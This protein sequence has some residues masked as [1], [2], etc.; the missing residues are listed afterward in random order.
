[1]SAHY[2]TLYF[3]E[4]VFYASLYFLLINFNFPEVEIEPPPPG[5]RPAKGGAM[6]GGG[7]MAG[8]G[9]GGAAGGQ[10]GTGAGVKPPQPRMM[11]VQP[12]SQAGTMAGMGGGM[13][14]MSGAMPGAGGPMPG[15]GGAMSGAGGAMPAPMG[16]VPGGIVA[17]SRVPMPM[18]MPMRSLVGS[19]SMAPPG[20][21]EPCK[22]EVEC[23]QMPS[24]PRRPLPILHLP[25]VF[26]YGCCGCTDCPPSLN[27]FVSF[28]LR[29]TMMMARRMGMR[30]GMLNAEG[31]PP[32][33]TS[34]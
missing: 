31:E 4:A 30:P 11:G 10:S 3:L 19:P 25:M 24:E 15:A 20:F 8:G 12:G 13:A 27:P 34:R 2:F 6:A 33:M 22:C 1:M 28:R 18:G 29:Y 17:Q 26:H 14:G 23:C 5:R 21:E 7:V 16:G 32:D 9:A